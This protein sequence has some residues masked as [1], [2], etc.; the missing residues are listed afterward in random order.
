M[1]TKFSINGHAMV[2]CWTCYNQGAPSMASLMHPPPKSSTIPHPSHSQVSFVF[3]HSQIKF[4]FPAEQL[5]LSVC[6][7][8]LQ[9]QYFVLLDLNKWIHFP[10]SCR[11]IIIPGL[12]EDYRYHEVPVPSDCILTCKPK[13]VLQ[14]ESNGSEKGRGGSVMMESLKAARWWWWWWGA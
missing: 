7:H 10:P 2:P 1:L 3:T 6:F 14:H 4:S 12:S 8:I 5:L 9:F 13:L 11:L